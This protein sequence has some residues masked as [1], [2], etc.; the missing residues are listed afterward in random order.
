MEQ[1]AGSDADQR[2]QKIEDTLAIYNL[3]ASH[4]PFADAGTPDDGWAVW[5]DDGLF[6]RDDERGSITAEQM[7][8]SSAGPVHTQAREEGIAHFSSL[9]YVHVDGDHAVAVS[10]LQLLTPIT[11]G[12]EVAVPGHGATRGYRM[13]LLSTNR[14]DCVRTPSGWRVR[15]RVAGP[16]DG[17]DASRAPLRAA[18]ERSPAPVR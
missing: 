6:I 11:D 9:P 3:I 17:S 16:V 18:F 12:E 7:V 8:Q 10:Y 1:S 4:P 14:W 2:L 13:H 15:T 5:T